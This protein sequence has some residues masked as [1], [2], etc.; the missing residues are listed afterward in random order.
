[1]VKPNVASTLYK[2]TLLAAMV[3]WGTHGRLQFKGRLLFSGDWPTK[4]LELSLGLLVAA[5]LVCG[6]IPW[7]HKKFRGLGIK[8][9]VHKKT[10]VGA[11]LMV[12]YLSLFYS[13]LVGNGVRVLFIFIFI[14]LNAMNGILIYYHLRD[15]NIT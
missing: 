6:L 15:T 1:M 14:I 5:A 12:V 13:G 8:Q 9:H 2:T 3:L 10:V 7:Y 11:A 4:F